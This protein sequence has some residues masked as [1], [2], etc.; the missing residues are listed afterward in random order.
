[1]AP[2]ANDD[3]LKVESLQNLMVSRAEGG[4]GD[5]PA[6]KSLRAELIAN[7]SLK[8][9]LPPFV[10]TCRD[11]HQFWTY[12]K[13]KFDTYK[14]RREFIWEGF[15]KVVSFLESGSSAPSDDHTTLIL[16]AF[17]ADEIS[18]LWKRALE[19][20]SSDPEGAI[21]LARSLLE[22]VSKHIIDDAGG[23]YGPSDDLPKLFHTASEHLQLA[24]SQH[25][26]QVF[27]QILGGCQTVVNGLGARRNKLGDAHGQGRKSVRPSARHAE[28][29]VNLAGTMATFLVATW[30]ARNEARNSQNGENA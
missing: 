16:G 1:M 24:P 22:T 4:Q 12:I 25:T 14:E 18:A 28:L 19:R 20:R 29:A 7:P 8:V 2:L 23:T 3:L 10:Q 30:K 26:E 21:T 13:G 6:Y 11:Q 15:A 27:K 9:L 17:D 5:P